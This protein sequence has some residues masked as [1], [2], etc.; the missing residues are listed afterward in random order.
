MVTIINRQ[1]IADVQ[2]D[3][4]LI[5]LIEHL[6]D[7][8]ACEPVIRYARK[9]K[10]KDRIIWV[11]K[12][13]YFE[14]LVGHPDLDHIVFADN[15]FQA[16]ELGA[17]LA[18]RGRVFNLHFTGRLCQDTQQVIENGNIKEINLTN[19]FQFGGLLEAFTQA[20]KLPKLSDAPQFY[21]LPFVYPPNLPD[22]YVIF[23]CLSLD[24]RRDW[25]LS[26]WSQLAFRLLSD[27][28]SVVEVGFKAVV[29][30]DSRSI[31]RY[32]DL[33]D[34]RHIQVIAAVIRGA[35]FFIGVDSAFAH[36]ANAL[37]TDGLVITGA[38]AGFS[39][40]MPYTGFYSE[41]GHLVRGDPK[42]ASA[43]RIENIIDIFRYKMNYTK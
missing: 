19:Y 11:C 30:V 25:H 27:G 38:L 40:Y 42:P 12:E 37:H 7:I 35:S 33:T 20:A 43:V 1:E 23:H 36:L 26:G 34:L 22:N 10:P 18:S 17:H 14:A 31:A 21:I 28:W 24:P 9:T 13:Q 16:S 6:G 8:I 4:T 2:G 5:I 3:F 29:D 41:P 39:N 32:Y 15:L